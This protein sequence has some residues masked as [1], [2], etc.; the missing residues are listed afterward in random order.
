MLPVRPPRAESR[1]SCPEIVDHAAAIVRGYETR[2]SLRQ[3]FYRLVADGTLPNTPSAYKQLSSRTGE[4][5]REGRFPALIDLG[6][7]VRRPQTFMGPQ[8]ARDYVA[9]VYRQIRGA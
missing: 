3:L 2:V 8:A 7:E 6:R 1:R 4:A 5:R 9:L